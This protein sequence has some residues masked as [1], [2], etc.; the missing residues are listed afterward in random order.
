MI[1]DEIDG[2]QGQHPFD[3]KAP[4]RHLR[5]HRGEIHKKRDSREVLQQHATDNEG[6]LGRPGGAGLPPDERF[7]VPIRN[8]L[9]VPSAQYGFEEDPEAYR[10]PRDVPNPVLLQLGKRVVCGGGSGGE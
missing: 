8:A 6:Y 9:P 1:D 5:A 3:V 2:N 4:A 7:D 10:Q